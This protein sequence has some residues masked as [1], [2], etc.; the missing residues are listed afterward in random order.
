MGIG[1]RIRELRE[2]RGMTQAELAELMGLQHSA[3]SLWESKTTRRNITDENL[4]KVAEV[5]GVSL[6]ELFGEERGMALTIEPRFTTISVSQAEKTLLDLF[7]SFPEKLQLLQL[8]QFV[9]CS[10]VRKGKQFVSNKS[11]D[12]FAG[13]VSED[14]H[15]A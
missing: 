6:A 13:A 7:R 2:K 4:K 1:D 14:S 3:V 9:E 12:G 8:A 10:K 15:A 5:L 11:S